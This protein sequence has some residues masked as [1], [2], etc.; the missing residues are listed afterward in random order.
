MVRE[1]I[2]GGLRAAL[3]RGESLKQAMLTFINAGYSQEEIENAARQFDA[4]KAAQPQQPI[5]PVLFVPQE[6]ASRTDEE[7][8]SINVQKVSSYGE[9]PIPVKPMVVQQPVVIAQ[10]KVSGYSG[11]EKL[12]G[13]TAIFILIALLVILLGILITL[14]LFKDEI[15][16]FFTS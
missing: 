15:M 14:F 1:D 4:D 2:L 10:Q 5:Q 6:V 11:T 3:Q 13:K 16:S 12:K 7:S 8:P 9:K